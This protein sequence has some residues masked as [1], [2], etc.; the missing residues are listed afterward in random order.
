MTRPTPIE[1]RKPK[2][3]QP[4]VLVVLVVCLGVFFDRTMDPSP[5][6]LLG[7]FVIAMLAWFVLIRVGKFRYAVLALLLSWATLGGL[8]H[9]IHWNWYPSQ[10][11][12]RFTANESTLVCIRLKLVNEPRSVAAK[13]QDSLNPIPAGNRTRVLTRVQA[14]RD[15]EDWVEAT[16]LAD[17]V[18]HDEPIAMQSGDVVEVFGRLV[19]SDSTRNPGQ[20]NFRD[21][22][23]SRRKLATVHCYFTDSVHRLSLPALAVF[24]LRSKLRKRLNELTWQHV[25]EKRAPFAA[26]ILLGNREQLSSVERERFLKTGT[27]HLLAISGLHIGILA[28]L[29]F[30]L[31]R[32]GAMRRT[33]ALLC[34][35]MFV[36]FYA[37]LVEFR[38]PVL[39]ASILIV[40]FSIARLK[41]KNGLSYNLLALAGLI[42]LAFNP[43]DL[44]Q[45]GPQ[46]SFLAVTTI[47][48]CR[49]WIYPG[50]E[51]DP[52]K[53]LIANT[54]GTPVRIFR[55]VGRNFWTAFKVSAVIWLAA[56]PLVAFHF[57]L[58]VPISL[59]LNPLVMIP[60]AIG[61][62][63][64][65]GVLVF[66]WFWSGAAGFFGQ[67]CGSSLG[68]I[69]LLIE[70]GESL[71]GGHFWASGPDTWAIAI[72]Y[73]GLFVLLTCSWTKLS[74]RWLLAIV[75]VWTAFAWVLPNWH[76]ATNGSVSRNREPQ[77][78][79][80]C[81]FVDTGHGCSV[82]LQLPGHQTVL[83]DAGCLG[84]A[85]Y[86]MVNISSVLWDQKIHHIDALV[87]SHA[88]VDHFNSAVEL[89]ERFSIGV[90]YLSPMMLANESEAVNLF[91]RA[92]RDEEIEVR[93]IFGGKRLTLDT[94]EIEMFV[95]GPTSSGNSGNDNSNSL[96]IL[97]EAFSKRL[98]LPGDLEDEGLQELLDTPSIDCDLVM[99]P[100]HGSLNS[101]PHEFAEWARPEEVVISSSVQRL[102][103]EAVE[104]FE[105]SGSRVWITGRDGA[106]RCVLSRNG[107]EISKWIHGDRN[108]GEYFSQRGFRRD[109]SK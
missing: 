83:Y 55:W 26:A 70:R 5:K 75:F 88:D 77:D 103:G 104:A 73:S 59:V 15:G 94:E 20:F 44:F 65:L 89:C 37:W 13:V 64:G 22:A 74:G 34:T 39:R 84:S 50:P 3:R 100:H 52:L 19:G 18:I 108:D 32:I 68:V 2:Q 27:V 53:R 93:E 31:Y 16:G 61:L 25:D 21:L 12:S 51:Q 9:H 78:E 96:V 91:L 47:V 69:D 80:C 42:V 92:L 1:N 107:L 102:K 7:A 8:W 10:T 36:I 98:L 30:L 45:I 97:V 109:L 35:I 56:V 76:T 66:G 81:T 46:F 90:V 48:F 71:P 95:L 43:S 82:V 60:I 38:P 6:V 28:A 23:R 86:G 4:L 87:I 101:R 63:S 29:F 14:I 41:G 33:A 58:V 99:A 105:D 54:R 17:L 62:Y 85:H 11:I 40:L 67:I 72:F 49:P 57:H 106:V 79:L 24:Q